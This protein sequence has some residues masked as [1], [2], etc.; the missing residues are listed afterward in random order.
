[1][2]VLVQKLQICIL[3]PKKEPKWLLPDT[4]PYL[5]IYLNVFASGCTPD[6]IGEAHG[7]V[8]AF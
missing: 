4:F 7:A 2:P 5:K 6:R 3:V 8:Q 1:M